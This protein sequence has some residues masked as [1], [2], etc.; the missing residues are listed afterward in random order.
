MWLVL[1]V[2]SLKKEDVRILG[3]ESKASYSCMVST[4]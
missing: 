3:R 4:F 1:G 2:T